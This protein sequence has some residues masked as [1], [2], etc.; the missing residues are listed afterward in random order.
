MEQES[1]AMYFSEGYIAVAMGSFLAGSLLTSAAFIIMDF[2]SKNRGEDIK[3]MKEHKKEQKT[4]EN[5]FM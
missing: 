5:R 3:T 1:I 4:D 2:L